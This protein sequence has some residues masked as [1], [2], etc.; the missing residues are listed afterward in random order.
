MQV[1]MQ[2]FLQGRD[3]MED[4]PIG[5]YQVGMNFQRFAPTKL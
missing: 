1:H 4:I 2:H 3:G 5:F